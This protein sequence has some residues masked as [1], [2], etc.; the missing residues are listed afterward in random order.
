MAQSED[1]GYSFVRCRLT[2]VGVGK[3]ILGRPW[4]PYSRVVFAQSSI[5]NTV[6]SDGWEDW[7]RPERQSTAFYGEFNCYGNGSDTA[8]RV[9][10]SHKLSP[11]EAAP[12]LTKAWLD[13][14]DWLEGN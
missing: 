7:G 5:S 4:A 2:S 1:T 11:G 13:G 10:W 6:R 9:P 8:R 12:F 3:S 14:K